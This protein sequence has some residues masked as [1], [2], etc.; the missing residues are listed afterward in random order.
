M[1]HQAAQWCLGSWTYVEGDEARVNSFSA[2]VSTA[3]VMVAA[4]AADQRHTASLSG[5]TA[6]AAMAPPA[7]LARF[8]CERRGTCGGGAP[9]KPHLRS[10]AQ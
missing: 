1:G 6:T 4:A 2:S 3:H 8:D 9:H 7:P 10:D 5:I